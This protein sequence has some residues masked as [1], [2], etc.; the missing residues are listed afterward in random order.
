MIVDD[1]PYNIFVISMMIQSLGYEVE[2]ALNGKE[3]FDLIKKKY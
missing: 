2:K 1:E 3:A